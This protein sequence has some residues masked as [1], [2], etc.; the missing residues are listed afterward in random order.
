MMVKG[1]VLQTLPSTDSLH[2]LFSASSPS[3]GEHLLLLG[4]LDFQLLCS[5]FLASLHLLPDSPPFS[6]SP[7][8]ISQALE[9]TVSS[10]QTP[11]PYTGSS[12][13]ETEFSS[14]GSCVSWALSKCWLL[15]CLPVIMTCGHRAPTG[16]SELGVPGPLLC[17]VTG[18]LS[19]RFLPRLP[20]SFIRAVLLRKLLVC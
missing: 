16:F 7:G 12:P 13:L 2:P 3:L 17:S 5:G 11:K 1:G 19:A 6:S 15:G 18:S 14:L 4:D 9:P 10:S 20:G 8:L